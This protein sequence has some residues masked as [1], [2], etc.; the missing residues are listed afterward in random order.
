MMKQPDT[1]IIVRFVLIAVAA[2]TWFV[3]AGEFARTMQNGREV[4]VPGSYKSVDAQPQGV[5]GILLAPVKGFV[6]AAQIVAFVLIVGGAFGMIAGT[7]AIEAGLQHIMRL[8]I[9][10]PQY[11]KAIIPLLMFSFSV[12]G[13]TFGMSE[14]VL[15]FILITIPFAHALGY[16]TIVGVA[17]PFIGAGV[18]FAGAVTNPF[19][20]GIAQAI[21]EVPTFSGWEYRLLVWF[22]LTLTAT[23]YVMR[24]A[25]KIEKKGSEATTYQGEEIKTISRVQSLVL[26]IFCFAIIILIIGSVSWGWYINEITGLF[27][28]TGIATSLVCRI[29]PNR[30]LALFIEGAR[31]M[32]PAALV[33]ALAKGILIV[34]SDGKIIDSMLHYLSGAV[35]GLHPVVSAQ[36][37][38]IIQNILNFFVPS[39]S[40]QAALTMPVMAPLSELVSVTRQTTVLIFQLGDGIGNMII[41]TSGVTMGVLSAAKLSYGN[42]VRWIWPLILILF[43]LAMLALI[44]PVLTGWS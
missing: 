40:G 31:G 25:A 44:P 7:K 42:W 43:M 41:P 15:L 3:P 29:S 33:I 6:A 14:E 23:L 9:Q 11:K 27:L 8:C 28:L 16:D 30:A 20:V 1:L 4:I 2:M 21:A 24:Y 19:T 10:R 37:M 5:G 13:A 39:G 35:R 12:T 32:L 38:F 36:L 22:V 17:I 34:A 26:L 18:G